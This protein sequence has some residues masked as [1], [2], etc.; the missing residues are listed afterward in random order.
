MKGQPAGSAR[1][2]SQNIT[3][4]P[5]H[6]EAIALWLSKALK[7]Q[8][9]LVLAATGTGCPFGELAASWVSVVKIPLYRRIFTSVAATMPANRLRQ[10]PVLKLNGYNSGS[11][12]CLRKQTMITILSAVFCLKAFCYHAVVPTPVNLELQSCVR[13]ASLWRSNSRTRAGW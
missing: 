13:Y 7:K 6:I 4:D 3:V 12:S 11:C 2:H 5:A 8:F 10:E 1:G 9:F